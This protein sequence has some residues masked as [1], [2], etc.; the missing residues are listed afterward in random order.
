MYDLGICTRVE[1]MREVFRFGEQK[2]KKPFLKSE[3]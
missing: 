3:V 1:R 2:G